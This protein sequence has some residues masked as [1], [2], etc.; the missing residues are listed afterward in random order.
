MGG[1][2]LQTSGDTRHLMKNHDSPAVAPAMDQHPRLP[3]LI[4]PRHSIYKPTSYTLWEITQ[5]RYAF[6]E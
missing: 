4:A 2:S 3:V 5:L 1:E 6:L